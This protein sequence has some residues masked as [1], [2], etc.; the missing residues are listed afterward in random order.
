MTDLDTPDGVFLLVEDG[1]YWL[2]IESEHSGAQAT[3][4]LPE[5]W[6]LAERA[7]RLAGGVAVRMPKPDMAGIDDV[8][9]HVQSSGARVEV[10]AD[11]T[12]L[13]V[14]VSAAHDT[15][16]MDTIA[17][18]NPSQARRFAAAVLAASD[19]AERMAAEAGPR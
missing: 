12:L 10:R 11:L 8:R 17:F 5:L 7:A 16:G 1:E 14:E 18:D 13:P 4:T 19:A 9:W 6:T 3:L 15:G 2:G